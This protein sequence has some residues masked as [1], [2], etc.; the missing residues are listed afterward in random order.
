[1]EAI[2]VCHQVSLVWG[3]LCAVAL[4][5]GGDPCLMSHPLS[6]SVLGPRGAPQLPQNQRRNFGKS[7]RVSEAVAVV[8]DGVGGSHQ[9]MDISWRGWDV[10][11]FFPI[12]ILSDLFES[13]LIW[14]KAQPKA[15]CF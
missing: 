8:R 7:P 2:E 1:M 14:S 9:P 15:L 13:C 10:G 11:Q 5:S 3:E 12:F 6:L 4:C